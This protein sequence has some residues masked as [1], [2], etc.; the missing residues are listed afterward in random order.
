MPG[1]QLSSGGVVSEAGSDIKV[2][3]ALRLTDGTF[4][5][6]GAVDIP[7]EL[8][9]E[10]G[11]AIV[12]SVPFPVGTFRINSPGGVDVSNELTV[13][14]SMM[15]Q[16]GIVYVDTATPLHF[17]ISSASPAERSGSY[18]EGRAIMDYRVVGGGYLPAFLGCGITGG[19]DVGSVSLIRTTGPEG[20]IT[21]DDPYAE[22]DPTNPNEEPHASI[23][24]NWEVRT[25][26]N[27]DIANR[28]ITFYWLPEHDNGKNL[29]EIDLY[30]SVIG[31][32]RFEKLNDASRT[33]PNS[34]I[35]L[36]TQRRVER[37]NQ[38]FTLSDKDNPLGTYAVGQRIVRIYPN[39]FVEK[40]TIK[41][42]NSG[43]YPVLTRIVDATGKL[44]Y[45]S[46][47]Q[48]TGNEVVLNDL[49]YLPQGN[50]WLH[51][52]IHGSDVSTHIIKIQ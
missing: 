49:G 16:H 52:H 8:A 51:L 25:T 34:N 24:A 48:P 47:Q 9:M 4:T 6:N 20:I 19:A 36:F 44:V 15:M 17:G 13:H 3:G 35:R 7:G 43:N 31:R 11:K 23:A 39:P 37:F 33:I 5:V 30:G 12:G 10:G 26:V 46:T 50:Y 27:P 45:R 21:R 29:N 28:D 42:E 2:D 14:D 41:L 32:D 38:V 1:T 40:L 18:I 22:F